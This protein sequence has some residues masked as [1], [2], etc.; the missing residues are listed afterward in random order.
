MLSITLGDG[1]VS[2]PKGRDAHGA[3]RQSVDSAL[4]GAHTSAIT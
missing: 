2:N 4:R 1:A 3:L